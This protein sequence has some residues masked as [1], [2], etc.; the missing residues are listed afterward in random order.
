MLSRV[1]RVAGTALLSAM[2]ALALVLVFVI[3]AAVTAVG[4]MTC[5]ALLT[6]MLALALVL[7][8]VIAAAV[9]AVGSMTGASTTATALFSTTASGQFCASIR[10]SFHIVSVI[11]Q[12]AHFCTQLVGICFLRVVVDGQLRR[13]H[14]VGVGLDTL[15]IRHI[16]LEFVGAF[17][18]HAV[19]LDGHG[20]LVL[21]GRFALL[22]IRSQRD[23]GC[24][25]QDD[26]SFH[27]VI[28]F[29]FVSV[30]FH[31]RGCAPLT[32]GYQALAPKTTPPFGHPF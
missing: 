22:G 10:I 30:F 27:I 31:P 15:E 4:S 8:S 20:L 26:D 17:L 2:M 12:L 3:A 1:L 23:D 6:T 29:L 5:T 19:G 7:V 9:T 18:A 32:P 16:L 28:I 13:L 14:V 25:S 11:T 21:R 24:Y